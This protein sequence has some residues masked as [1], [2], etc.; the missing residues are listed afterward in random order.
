M[1]PIREFI[2]WYEILEPE[3]DDLRK[4][5]HLANLYA[6][7]HDCRD[8]GDDLSA[9]NV[10]DSLDEM[11]N[12]FNANSPVPVD[13]ND[14]E[15]LENYGLN[16]IVPDEAIRQLRHVAT[17]L[18]MCGFDVCYLDTQVASVDDLDDYTM[19]LHGYIND[20]TEHVHTFHVV[21]DVVTEVVK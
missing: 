17:M 12:A 5:H 15:F 16:E 10:Y 11:R 19:S 3:M 13:D 18:D 1:N 4:R 2:E 7:W 20:D 8:C 6:W 21:D 9:F 14:D